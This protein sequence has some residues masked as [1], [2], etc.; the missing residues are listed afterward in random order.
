[1]YIYI[2]TNNSTHLSYIVAYIYMYNVLWLSVMSLV[3]ICNIIIIR[4]CN[5]VDVNLFVCL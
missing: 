1:M 5:I 4:T 2:Y 3:S